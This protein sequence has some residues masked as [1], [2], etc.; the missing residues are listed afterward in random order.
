MRH[1]IVT[2]TG[3]GNP[4]REMIDGRETKNKKL[5]ALI[6]ESCKEAHDLFFKKFGYCDA[7]HRHEEIKIG[8][9][10]A[11]QGE[12]LKIIAINKEK[13]HSFF[14]TGYAFGLYGSGIRATKKYFSDYKKKNKFVKFI[15]KWHPILFT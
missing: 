9:E 6:K 8:V 3:L 14:E 10:P 5:N 4:A 1:R 11:Y 12:E 13:H 2:G 15:E 7:Q